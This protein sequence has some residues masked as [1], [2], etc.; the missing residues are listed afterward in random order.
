MRRRYQVRFTEDAN[1]DLQ[2]LYA[3]LA[4]N[5]VEAAADALGALERALE[6]VAEFPWSCRASTAV[7]GPRFREL[8]I[9][10]GASGYVALFEIEGDDVV[11]VLAVR[12]QRESDF[13]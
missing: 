12:H 5:S 9:S 11:T 13:H 2:R 3:F 4:E 10:F 6:L 1:D 8:V 7:V